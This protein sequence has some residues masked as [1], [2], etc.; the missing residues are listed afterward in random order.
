MSH[1][2]YTLGHLGVSGTGIH[3]GKKFDFVDYMAGGGLL[4]SEGVRDHLP[5]AVL[6]CQ[7]KVLL[8]RLGA[9]GTE[10]H[11]ARNLEKT[12]M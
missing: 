10:L 6:G 1:T 2:F 8:E 7:H 5:L 3:S 9:R 12:N 4:R 11:G